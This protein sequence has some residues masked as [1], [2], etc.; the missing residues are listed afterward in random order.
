MAIRLETGRSSP[1]CPGSAEAF[2][3]LIAMEKK[4]NVGL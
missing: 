4:A 2:K 1:A 3:Q